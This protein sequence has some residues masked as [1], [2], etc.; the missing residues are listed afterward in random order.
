MTRPARVDPAP[1]GRDDAAAPVAR[2][3]RHPPRPRHEDVPGR[4]AARGRRPRPD[5]PQGE[6][7]ALVGPSGCGKTTTL[8]DDQPADRADRRHDRGRR[9]RH[10]RA[11]GARAAARHRLRHPA[12]R[13]VPAPHDRRQHR[14]RPPAARLGP[15]PAS[16]SGSTSSSTSSASTPTL[17]GRYPAALSGGQQ[18]RVGVARALAA[19]PPVLLMDEPYSRGRPDRAGPPAGRAARPAAPGAQDDR[20][21]HPRHRRGHQARRPHR[22]PQRRRRAR[23][24]RPARGAAARR[25]PTSS[26]A[27]FLGE[28]RG[29]QAAGAA[30]RSRD[31]DAAARAGRRAGDATADD[32]RAVMAE[33]GVDWVGVLDGDRLL[34]WVGADDARRVATSGDAEPRPFAAVVH[35]DDARCARRSTPSST[36]RTRVAVVVDRTTM[37]AATSACSRID[38]LGRGGHAVTGRVLAADEP[39][40]RLGLGRP[41]TSTRSAEAPSSSTSGSPCIAVGVGFVHLAACW[42]SSAVRWRWTYAPI[43]GVPGV[44][45]TI[46]SLALFAARSIP[47]TGLGVPHR[48]RS[49]SSATRC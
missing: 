44:L 17:L 45:Y 43:T 27:D 19:D 26:S 5:D 13:A 10:P 28:E 46:P 33:H 11:A 32:A 4:P 22:H 36:S 30:A 48:A 47:I 49:R 6:L 9:R 38:E 39:L 3:G 34:G 24:V 20:A 35:P 29:A 15:R 16:A 40:R 7:V 42:R 31:V 25:R 14:H 1:D 12:D 2:R 18:Q 8:Q 21:R 37:R 41:T 23:A